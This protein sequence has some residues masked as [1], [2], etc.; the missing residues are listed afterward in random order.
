MKLERRSRARTC[1]DLMNLGK[2]FELF[3]Q[4]FGEEGFKWGNNA[5]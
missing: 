4:C 2:E 5:I 3:S 1:L